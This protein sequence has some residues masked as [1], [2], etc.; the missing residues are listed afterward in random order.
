MPSKPGTRSLW[1]QAV[2]RHSNAAITQRC[3]IKMVSEDSA[4]AMQ[5]LSSRVADIK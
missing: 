1:I 2:L 5:K 4:L 3:Y